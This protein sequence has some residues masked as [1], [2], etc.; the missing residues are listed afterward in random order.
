MPDMPTYDATIPE[1]EMNEQYEKYAEDC[2]LFNIENDKYF[3]ELLE[4]L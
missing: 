3:Q 2:K 1:K 4:H